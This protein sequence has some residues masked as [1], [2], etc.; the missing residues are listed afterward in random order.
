MDNLSYLQRH[1]H[2][3]AYEGNYSSAEE[4][5][6]LYAKHHHWCDET[7]RA[8]RNG[9]DALVSW[10]RNLPETKRPPLNNLS[11][12]DASA[13]I[14]RLETK[15][16][17][18]S[19]I[20]GYKRGADALTKVIRAAGFKSYTFDRSYE[21]FKGVNPQAKRHPKNKL[22]ETV[23]ET[24]QPVKTRAKLKVLVAMLELGLATS[25]ACNCCW[26]DVREHGRELWTYRTARYPV[27]ATLHAAL[28][29]WKAFFPDGV[30]DTSLILAWKP[31]TAREWLKRVR[32]ATCLEAITTSR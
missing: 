24:I 16:L 28:A 9:A 27:N 8:R 1:A 31:A 30:E 15:G 26:K 32:T 4:L 11:R 7:L 20:K 3:A 29:G 2:R 19:T 5:L 22:D 12:E 14:S 18:R 21:P 25:E 17:S 23:L 10:W 13:F 6:R